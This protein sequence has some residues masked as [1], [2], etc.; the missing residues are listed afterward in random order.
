MYPILGYVLSS[1][2]FNMWG[3]FM[4]KKELNL[5]GTNELIGLYDELVE[6][7]DYCAFLCDAFSSLFSSSHELDAEARTVM[8]LKRYCEDLK[9]RSKKLEVQFDE[10]QRR[11]G[12]K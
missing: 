1:K 9:D 6:F 5:V 12:R 7:N 4:S 11:L 3:V 8:G 2:I 10:V